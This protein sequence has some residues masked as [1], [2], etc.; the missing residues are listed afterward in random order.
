MNGDTD[1]RMGRGGPEQDPRYNLTIS[2]S[3]TNGKTYPHRT[4][5]W[6]AHRGAVGYSSVKVAVREANARFAP[7]GCRLACWAQISRSTLCRQA[8]GTVAVHFD[9]GLHA[10]GCYILMAQD[11]YCGRNGTIE[12]SRDECIACG[13]KHKAELM[14]PQNASVPGKGVKS[15]WCAGEFQPA[16]ST[17]H[18]SA[19]IRSGP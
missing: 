19:A 16:V 5:V 12:M 18:T 8:D 17:S 3:L 10:D 2:L 15:I 11:K 1:W 4:I 14:Q 6:P 7:A 9:N 13:L